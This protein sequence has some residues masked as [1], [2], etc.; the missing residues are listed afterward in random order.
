MYN[1]FY[2]CEELKKAPE[3]PNTVTCMWS[4]FQGCS[5]LTEGKLGSNVVNIW[6]CF[7]DCTK[8][9][10]SPEIP[11]TIENMTQTFY[12]CTT[13]TN[14]PNIPNSVTTMQSTFQDCISLEEVP[15]IPN[16]VI[17]MSGTFYKCTNLK[18]AP[19]IGEN[20]EDIN[21]AF[22]D[23]A[24][25]VEAP[26]ISNK[27]KFMRSTFNRCTNL[28]KPPSKIPS[29][30]IN[31]IATFRD[32]PILQGNIEINAN[33]TDENAN[34]T[35][36]YGIIGEKYYKDCFNNSSTSGNGL[37]ITSTNLQLQ[38]N[39]YLILKNIVNTKSKDSNIIMQP[40]I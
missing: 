14:V 28:V 33:L 15:D 16:K 23:C 4:T 22:A 31:M 34:T 21:S 3:I 6:N 13:L 26:E 24:S 38:E 20:V 8:L 12:G 27:V 10:N 19:K 39:D 7:M 1:T 11:N 29:T 25:L 32:C 9:V 30:V 5:N 36:N 35:D 40:Q 37:I 2:N 18:K 17:N